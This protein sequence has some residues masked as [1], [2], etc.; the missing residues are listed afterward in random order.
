MSTGCD[1]PF[2]TPVHPPP[3]LSAMAVTRRQQAGHLSNR[4]VRGLEVAA[5]ILHLALILTVAL[6][7]RVILAMAQRGKAG[8]SDALENHHKPGIWSPAAWFL[9]GQV[10]QLRCADRLMQQCLTIP[11]VPGTKSYS[12]ARARHGS[13]SA[14]GARLVTDGRPEAIH[15]RDPGNPADPRR[16]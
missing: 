13:S 11:P 6:M 12:E 7:R 16:H 5:D 2:D 14:Q 1:N 15:A 3:Y 9:G 10:D 8:S 4:F